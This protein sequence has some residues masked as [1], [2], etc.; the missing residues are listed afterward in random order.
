MSHHQ[1]CS[2]ALCHVSLCNWFKMCYW[3]HTDVSISIFSIQ[4]QT[5]ITF[6]YDLNCQQNEDC[7]KSLN[8]LFNLNPIVVHVW[9]GWILPHF[10]MK[11]A[12]GSLVWPKISPSITFASNFFFHSFMLCQIQF[13]KLFVVMLNLRDSKTKFFR[14][15]TSIWISRLPSIIKWKTNKQW[16]F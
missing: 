1:L 6:T 11:S 13:F 15:S 7:W 2:M 12:L 10:F 14:P 9:D 5:M 4:L 16:I 3:H 8:E